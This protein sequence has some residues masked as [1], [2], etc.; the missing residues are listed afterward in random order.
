MPK[1]TRDAVISVRLSA[2]E[3]D[4]LKALAESQGGSVSDLIRG[5]VRRETGPRL[6]RGET[7]AAASAG[8]PLVRPRWSAPTGS[9]VDGFTLTVPVTDRWQRDKTE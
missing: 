6:P 9:V 7:S 8:S 4:R 2:D 3:Q 5:Y 1:E